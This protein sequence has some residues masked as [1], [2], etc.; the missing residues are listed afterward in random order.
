MRRPLLVATLVLGLALVGCAGR[1]KEDTEQPTEL[2]PIEESIHPTRLWSAKLGG[3]AETLRLGLAPA[4]DGT[5]IFAA[6]HA[7]RLTAFD[8]QTG[9]ERWHSEIELPLA[10][11]PGYG[12]DLLVVGSTDG[13]IAA[14]AARDGSIRWK[15]N[16]GAEILARPLIA[17]GRVFVRTVDGHLRALE[18]GS[19]SDLWSVQREVPRLSLRGNSTPVI[20]GN[21][22]IVGFDDGKVAAFDVADGDQ[23]WES[24]VAPQRGRTEIERLSDIDADLELVGGDLYVAG[25]QSRTVKVDAESGQEQWSVELSS[26]EAPGIDWIHIYVTDDKSEVVSLDL[27]S[28]AAAWRQSALRLRSVT[29]P[30]PFGQAV[31]VGDFE[32]YLHW[33]AVE[34]GR[35]IGRV[36]AD[37]GAIQNPP[38]VVGDTLYVQTDG[39]I[40]SAFTLPQSRRRETSEQSQ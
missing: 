5:S 2:G 10:A 12:E 35:I 36:R 39:G 3:E 29:G 32:G 34:D 6:A 31:V 27:E 14:V 23:A 13:G 33:L 11:G 40:L 25:F 26:Y 15:R 8:A 17:G 4:S 28:G 1:D 22:I 19:G 20:S 9:A 38:L 37:G 7:G 18:A 24:V 21:R 30:T 16:L